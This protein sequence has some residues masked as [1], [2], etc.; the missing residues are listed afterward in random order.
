M[1]DG[2]VRGKQR[3]YKE[4][5]TENKETIVSNELLTI[6]QVEGGI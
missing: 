4:F 2:L 6:Y 3:D 1:L 5:M